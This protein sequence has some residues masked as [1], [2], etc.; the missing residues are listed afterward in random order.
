MK[1]GKTGNNHKNIRIMK[2]VFAYILLLTITFSCY[3]DYVLDYEFNGVYFPNPVNVRT[4]VVGEG[5][6][7]RVGAQLGGVLENNQNRNVNF[8]IDNSLVT[9]DILDQMQNHNWFWVNE[10]AKKVTNLLPLPA[11]FYTLSNP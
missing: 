9:P 1:V 3:D 10:P 2:K 8:I 4:V 11:D 7:I 5:L 6:K